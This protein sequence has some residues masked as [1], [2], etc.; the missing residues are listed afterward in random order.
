MVGWEPLAYRRIADPEIVVRGHS[1][2]TQ[3][4]R[5]S[6]ESNKLHRQMR[7]KQG[8]LSEHMRPHCR[9]V[10]QVLQVVPGR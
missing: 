3:I 6:Q 8:K 1:R 7:E 9:G 10:D 4:H 5:P 2:T